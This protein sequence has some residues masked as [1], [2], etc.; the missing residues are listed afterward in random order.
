M[1]RARLLKSQGNAAFRRAEFEDAASVYE[2]GIHYLRAILNV[3]LLLEQGWQ[4]HPRPEL[5]GGIAA[6]GL[7]E[8][9][10][11]L[12]TFHAN[13]S[14][15][16]GSLGRFQEAEEDAEIVCGLESEVSFRVFEFQ[17]RCGWIDHPSPRC[18]PLSLSL[19]PP[20]R[21]ASSELAQRILSPGFPRPPSKPTESSCRSLPTE[22]AA[23][24][25]TGSEVTK[26]SSVL[27]PHTSI[28]SPVDFIFS[29]ETCVLIFFFPSAVFD[30]RQ[31]EGNCEASIR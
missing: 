12:G 16:F 29:C 3:P 22:P 1:A 25:H 7:P 30:D 24:L 13:R 28:D 9:V 20:S 18:L 21:P 27:S 5:Y 19:F 11:L 17:I 6:E 2:R 10:L 23:V 4:E 26:E 8:A 15:C 31:I 14:G